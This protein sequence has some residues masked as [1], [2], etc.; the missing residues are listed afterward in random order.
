MH[1]LEKS[2]DNEQLLSE[3]EEIVIQGFMDRYDVEYEE[4]KEIFDETKKFLELASE[5]GEEGKGLFIDKPLLIID[6]MWHT[7]IL[8]TK[9][10][11]SFCFEKFN[12]FIHHQPTSGKE[13]AE[14]NHRLAIEPASVLKEQEEKL[15][16]QY[17]RIYDKFG[18][19]TLLKWYDTWPSKYTPDYISK[20]KKAV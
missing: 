19:D 3:N 6:E 14:L 12:R 2:L 17:S 13:K 9:Q 7:F 10:Y 11:M 5:L 4:A 16:E 18:P 1:Q 15:K 20:I 8:H